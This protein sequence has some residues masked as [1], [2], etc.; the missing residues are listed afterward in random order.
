MSNDNDQVFPSFD[1]KELEIRTLDLMLKKGVRY[2]YIYAHRKTERIVTETNWKLLDDEAKAEWTSACDEWIAMSKRDKKA[3]R[4][5]LEIEIAEHQ[6]KTA[7][8]H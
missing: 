1:A 3:W 4:R 7:T 5:A 6:A 8:K 2:G